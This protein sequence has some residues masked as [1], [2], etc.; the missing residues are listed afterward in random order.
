M[1]TT[2][3]QERIAQLD[4]D[5]IDQAARYTALQLI[6]V[7]HSHVALAPGD[8]TEYRITIVSPGGMWAYSEVIDNRYYQVA[9]CAS[10][11]AGY[12]WNG[13]KLDPSYCAEKWTNA[14]SARGIRE[15]T[16]AVM[17]AYLNRVALYL[18]DR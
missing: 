8:A 12:P 13:R 17:S 5:H 10:F 15:W 1:T 16:G 4:H 3:T 6:G 14:G 18:E 11:G 9:L 7:G 2:P